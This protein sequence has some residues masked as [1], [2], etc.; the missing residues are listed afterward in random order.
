MISLAVI[1]SIVLLITL[2]KRW[3][4]HKP[5]TQGQTEGATEHSDAKSK[6]GS[7]EGSTEH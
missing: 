2:S 6:K 5:H 7:T 3:K 4:A 1:L